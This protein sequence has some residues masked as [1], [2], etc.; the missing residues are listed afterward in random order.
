MSSI[1]DILTYL[2]YM[3]KHTYNIYIYKLSN[4]AELKYICLQISF[5]TW[6]EILENG[7]EKNSHVLLY[8]V[9]NRMCRV[10]NVHFINNL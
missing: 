9:H 5:Q 8:K 10:Q 2:E 7:K 3:Y 1:Y 6:L 4:G